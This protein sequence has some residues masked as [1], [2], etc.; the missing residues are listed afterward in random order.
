LRTIIKRKRL[1]KFNSKYEDNRSDPLQLQLQLKVEGEL[2]GFY[3]E[4][5]G[6]KLLIPEELAAALRQ[7]E[8]ELKQ[9]KQ[10]L[11]EM[12]SMLEEYRQQFGEL[13]E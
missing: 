2:I 4:Y 12:Q 8:T 10:K 6:E 9:E 7:K 5:T 3:R 13:S 11:S 1:T